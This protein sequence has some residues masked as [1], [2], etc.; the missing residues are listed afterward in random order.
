MRWNIVETLGL[1]LPHPPDT[2]STSAIL[3]RSWIRTGDGKSTGKHRVRQ[4]YVKGKNKS[5]YR[6]HVVKWEALNLAQWSMGSG[7]SI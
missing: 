2:H 5:G 7:I 1:W 3:I 6:T 4:E